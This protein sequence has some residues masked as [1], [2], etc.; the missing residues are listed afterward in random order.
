MYS[1]KHTFLLLGALTLSALLTSSAAAEK[2]DVTG[3]QSPSEWEISMQPK[4]SAAEIEAARWHDLYANKTASYSYEETSLMPDDKDPDIILVNTRTI[5]LDP[6][7]IAEQNKKFTAQLT[8]ADRVAYSEIR[9]AFRISDHTYAIDRS[10][11]FSHD[12]KLLA[13]PLYERQFKPIPE[14]TLAATMYEIAENFASTGR[15]RIIN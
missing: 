6:A 15:T 11:I 5:Y 3:I 4:P 1:N 9:L 7:L 14:K 2:A 12:G 10:K 8:G 13:A